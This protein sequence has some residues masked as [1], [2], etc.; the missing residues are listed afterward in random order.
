MY[1]WAWARRTA[2]SE[3]KAKRPRPRGERCMGD[4]KDKAGGRIAQEDALR[5]AEASIMALA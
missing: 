4:D 3:T 5:G 2:E 1:V